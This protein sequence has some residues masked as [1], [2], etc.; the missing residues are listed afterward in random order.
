VVRLEVPGLEAEDLDLE[1]RNDVLVVLC[2]SL[3]NAFISR[4]PYVY[5]DAPRLGGL[6][7]GGGS[8]G[9]LNRS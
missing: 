1:V 7:L 4:S 5:I 3:V 8:Q 9:P 6:G 2:L